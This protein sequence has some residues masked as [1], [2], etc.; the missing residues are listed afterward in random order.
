MNNGSPTER[1][2]IGGSGHW[3]DPWPLAYRTPMDVFLE[4]R[5]ETTP[6]GNE[7]AMYWGTVLEDVVAREYSERTGRR[8]AARVS[9]RCSAH[10][11]H[12]FMLANI[13][14]AV[15]VPEI[16]GNVRW[17]DGRLTTDRI[18]E[19]KTA[20]CFAADQWG[21]VGTDNVPDAYLLQCQWY[22]GITRADVADLAVL[23]AA[24]ITASTASPATTA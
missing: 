8:G 4:K 14:R 3:R 20:N 9:R 10:P 15:I 16:S 21:D 12:D 6:T 7:Q 17:K 24:A 1:K 11:E 19:C 23:I 22:M 5:S 2:G 13:D 18:L